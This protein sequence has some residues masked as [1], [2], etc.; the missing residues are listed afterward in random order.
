MKLLRYFLSI[1]KTQFLNAHYFGFKGLF[2]FRIWV[3]W[4]TKL[5]KL[6]KRGSITMQPGSCLKF[7][8]SDGTVRA[9]GRP[10]F[11]QDKQSQLCVQGRLAFSQGAQLLIGKGGVL[12]FGPGEQG[13]NSNTLIICSGTMKFGQ[14]I[15][16][17][18][19][20]TFLDSDG[21]SVDGHEA[22]GFVTV[23]REFLK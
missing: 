20:C 23:G 10:I 15:R 1:P 19:G 11:S 14:D 2:H 18:W 13:F 4:N 3:A 17:G 16:V 6:G 8:M 21:H 22:K 12:S 9:E 7:G 5:K